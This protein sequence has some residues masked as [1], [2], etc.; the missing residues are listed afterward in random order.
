MER[1]ATSFA[2]LMLITLSA[3][4]AGAVTEPT[5]LRIIETSR[6]RHPSPDPTGIAFLRSS[7]RLLVSDSEVDEIPRLWAGRNLF[8][9]TRRGML[10]GTAKV[11]VR[12]FEPEDIV[13]DGRRKLLFVADDDR[14]AV[15]R[16]RVG[17]DRRIGTVDDRA[18]EILDTAAFGSRDPEG[19][20]LG[21]DGRSFFVA[22]DKRS[23]VFHVRRGR[24]RRFG[25]ADDIV[26]SFDVGSLGAEG[27]NGLAYRPGQRRLFIAAE[28]RQIVVTTARGKLVS[29]IDIS[30]AGVRHPSAIALVA[31]P[32]RS[33]LR[34]YVADRGRDNRRYPRENDGRI[35][36]L[37]LAR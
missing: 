33:T 26:R 16:F 27:P 13:W 19:L 28:P 36:V 11:T 37:D 23:R 12:S 2:A 20:A 15:I 21:R 14:D 25:T 1:F 6:W 30:S 22:D 9:T 18:V 29:R 5:L 32:A 24:D 7:R 3:S 17:A 31:R 8:L 10:R 35:F 4:S 34:L